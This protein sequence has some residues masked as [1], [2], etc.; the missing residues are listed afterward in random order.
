[1]EKLKFDGV[2]IITENVNVMKDFYEQVL[3]GD[4]EGDENYALILTKDAKLSIFSR[5]CMETMAPGHTLEIGRSSCVI[6]IEV[7]NVDKEYELL[8]KKKVSIVKLPTTQPWGIRSVW[9]KDPDGNIVNFHADV[10]IS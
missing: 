4:A 6:E 3:R 5:K 10:E 8:K 9:F 1:M 7:D 2:C